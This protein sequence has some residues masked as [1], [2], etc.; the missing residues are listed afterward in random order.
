MD[1]NGLLIKIRAPINI[2]LIKYWGKLH[3]GL[4]IPL[5]SSF[6][7]TLDK[8]QIYS[9]TSIELNSEQYDSFQLKDK[10]DNVI[11]T[12]LPKNFDKLK[13][14]FIAYAKHKYKIEE[15]YVKIDSMNSFP[16]KAGLASSASG[17]S[18]IAMCFCRL[19]N[20]FE[21]STDELKND[22]FENIKDWFIENRQDKI[23]KV[24]SIVLLLRIIS[25]SSCRS[26]YLFSVLQIGPDLMDMQN[27]S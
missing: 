8:S 7:L 23:E 18:C 16:T 27:E 14:Y 25:G 4:N 9:E 21:E 20:Y 22:V 3:E 10:H 5:N 1:F 19:F 6:S 11:E 12:E 13:S 24:L 26:T 2:A 15:F 17:L